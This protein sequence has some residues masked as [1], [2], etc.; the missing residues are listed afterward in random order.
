MRGRCL[1]V[2][3]IAAALVHADGNYSIA[4]KWVTVSGMS[5]ADTLPSG[6]SSALVFYPR[7]TTRKYAVL[8]FAHGVL[9]SALDAEYYGTMHGVASHGHIVIG[10][11]RLWS[12]RF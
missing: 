10:N 1:A 3:L 6:N 12:R 4:K 9:S 11:I 7:D 2:L 5:C 8:G